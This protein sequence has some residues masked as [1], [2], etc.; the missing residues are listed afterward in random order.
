[1]LSKPIVS[2]SPTVNRLL[3]ARGKHCVSIHLSSLQPNST[4][5]ELPNVSTN[6]HCR[7]SAM[8]Q[9]EKRWSWIARLANNLSFETVGSTG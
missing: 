4:L 2:E 5:K 1:M 3:L 8:K 9:T 6:V 7:K